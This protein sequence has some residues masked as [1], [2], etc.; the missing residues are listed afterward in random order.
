MPSTSEI[1]LQKI[2]DVTLVSRISKGDAAAIAELYRR[3]AAA[4]RV[5]LRRIVGVAEA[6]DLVHEV[7]LTVWLRAGSYTPSRACVAA[8]VTWIARNKGID[9]TRRSKRH[10]A[11]TAS[12]EHEIDAPPS[13]RTMLD[14]TRARALVADLPAE[15]RSTLEQA[16]FEG[17]SYSEIATRDQVALGTVKSRA[18]RG[19]KAIRDLLDGP[20]DAAFAVMGLGTAHLSAAIP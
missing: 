19:M 5:T 13:T 2:D 18:A 4:V 9:H 8:W 17:L 6:D 12:L 20:A 3:Y 15:Q 7:F 10:A 11:A 16:F 1:E 14:A